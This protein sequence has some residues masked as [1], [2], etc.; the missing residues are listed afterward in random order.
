MALLGTMVDEE[1]AR[2]IGRSQSAVRSFRFR[3]GILPF[4]GSPDT[5]SGG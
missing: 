4:E 2:K 3:L 5:T 1:L